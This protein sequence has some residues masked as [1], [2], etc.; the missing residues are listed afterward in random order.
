MPVA[1][2]KTKA[3]TKPAP[4]QSG[5]GKK[6]GDLAYPVLTVNGV[7][8]P[9][10]NLVTK[11]DRAKHLL[12]WEDEEGYALRYVAEHPK[13]KAA[14]VSYGDDYLLKDGKGRKV[15][16]HRNSKNRPFD[17]LHCRKLAQ[18]ILQGKWEFNCETIIISRVGE[19]H[20]GQHRLIALVLAARS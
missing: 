16:C 20:S 2:P 11:A 7:A 9:E 12:G 19:V 17:E 3:V 5:K 15:R 13:V 8:V 10:E 1:A 14:K 18:D 4:V 6:D